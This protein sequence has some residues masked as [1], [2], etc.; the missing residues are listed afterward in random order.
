M[1]LV[2][3]KGCQEQM[4]EWICEGKKHK[5]P[6]K[7]LF[8]P[9]IYH[10]SVILYFSIFLF[11]QDTHRASRY[12]DIMWTI[13]ASNPVSS[14]CSQPLLVLYRQTVWATIIL[15]L[16]PLTKHPPFPSLPRQE[17]INHFNCQKTSDLRLQSNP[18]SLILSVRMFL[19]LSA[20]IFICSSSVLTPHPPQHT[21]TDTQTHLPPF[22]SWCHMHKRITKQK[23]KSFF[24]IP[25]PLSS[26]SITLELPLKHLFHYL[27]QFH[28][29]N[30]NP[31]KIPPKLSICAHVRACRD[32]CVLNISWHVCM[33]W[34]LFAVWSD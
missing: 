13:F 23:R 34:Y 18:P 27:P 24:F 25:P 2:L 17:D 11:H 30:R 29:T 31:A 19:S 8:A 7:L 12:Q 21:H 33:L 20:F 14:G 16:T 3:I 5:L 4:P 1:D 32:E 15:N 28:Y 6:Q 26:K 9:Y 10:C 22:P